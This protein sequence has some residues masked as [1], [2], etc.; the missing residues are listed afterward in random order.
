[1]KN[2]ILISFLLLLV[3][4]KWRKE[5]EEIPPGTVRFENKLFVDVTEISNIGWREFAYWIIRHKGWD[6]A[7]SILSDTLSRRDKEGKYVEIYYRHLAYGHYPVVEIYFEKAK[8]YAKWRTDRVLEYML[9]RD[10]KDV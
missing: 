10:K 3:S 8:E 4:R 9:I 5:K 1:M 2:L 7:Q 6:T